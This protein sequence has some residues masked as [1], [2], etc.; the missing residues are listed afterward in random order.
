MKK[1]QKED[2]YKIL[3]DIYNEK[4]VICSSYISEIKSPTIKVI[5]R[6]FGNLENACIDYC[7]PYTKRKKPCIRNDSKYK[8][9][10]LHEKKVDNDGTEIEIIKYNNASNIIIRFN[11]LYG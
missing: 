7:I 3:N 8:H 4:G 10:R 11:D 5:N 2:I 9:K 1:Y 6:L